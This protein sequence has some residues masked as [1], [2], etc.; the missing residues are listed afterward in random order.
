MEPTEGQELLSLSTSVKLLLD[1][2]VST[3]FVNNI[4]RTKLDVS[5]LKNLKTTLLR[6]F[7]ALNDADAVNK[8]LYELRLTLSEVQFLFIEIN[9][10]YET[11]TTKRY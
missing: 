4:R 8:R 11:L 5:L 2:L 6:V 9:T 10:D 3:E 7:I 1:E